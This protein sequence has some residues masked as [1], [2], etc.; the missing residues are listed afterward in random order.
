M[1]VKGG[2]WSIVHFIGSLEVYPSIHPSIPKSYIGEVCCWHHL[3]ANLSMH[4]KRC[5]TCLNP[6]TPGYMKKSTLDAR[7]PVRKPYAAPISIFLP[8][9][10]F[11]SIV[12]DPIIVSAAITAATKNAWVS[13]LLYAR[14]TPGSCALSIV[15]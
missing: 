3:D 11:H 4:I 13:A 2:V 15:D 6:K 9:T 7:K 14:V 8:F 1:I 10:L 12:A 5:S